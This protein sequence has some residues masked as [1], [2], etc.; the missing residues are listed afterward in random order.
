[1]QKI[2]PQ[3][4]VTSKQIYANHYF[5]G[6]LGL[7]AFMSIPDESNRSYLVYENR[8]RAD[9]LGGLFGKMKRGIVQ[10]KAVDNLKNILESSKNKPQRARVS[11]NRVCTAWR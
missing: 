3:V 10:E 11:R 2:G 8:S 7:T 9:V 6:S 4:L 1:M 5:D